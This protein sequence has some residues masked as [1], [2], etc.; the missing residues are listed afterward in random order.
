MT[1]NE[2]ITSNSFICHDGDNIIYETIT[3]FN[4][5]LYTLKL[6]HSM[7]ELQTSM[8]NDKCLWRVLK[9]G[10]MYPL[11]QGTFVKLGK[12]KLRLKEVV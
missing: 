2:Q 8:E 9:N 12:V 11:D 3:D 1:T 10:E 5:K 6:D 4:K 7:I